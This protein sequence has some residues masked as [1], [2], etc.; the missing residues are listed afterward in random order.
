[1][2][3]GENGSLEIGWSK[4]VPELLTQFQF[5]LVRN[6]NSNNELKNA[7]EDIFVNIFV[8]PVKEGRVINM[9]YVKIFTKT[10]WI[11][12]RYRFWKRR[13][14]SSVYVGE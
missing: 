12:K 10:N 2:Q 14:Q 9:E 11:Y 8:A 3:L 6:T 13:I 1:M 7:Y 5:Q 4:N